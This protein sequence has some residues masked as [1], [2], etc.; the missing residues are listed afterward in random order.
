[1]RKLKLDIETLNVQSFE[2]TE[3]GKSAQGTVLGHAPTQ[4]HN[5]E[6]GSAFDACHTGLCIPTQQGQGCH[7]Y[8]PEQCPSAVDACP[9]G[10]GC[11]DPVL[12]G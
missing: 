1:M 4:G 11:T 10:R 7:T 5:V 6:C 12:C 2:T 9:S 3:A 8:D